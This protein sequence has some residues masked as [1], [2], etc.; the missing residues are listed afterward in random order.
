[1]NLVTSVLVVLAIC[2]PGAPTVA[3]PVA[4]SETLMA[5]ARQTSGSAGGGVLGPCSD[6]AFQTSGARW[7]TSLDWEFKAGS[8]PK[9]FRPTAVESVL[10]RAFSNVTEAR[11]DC[12]L[13]DNV[14]AQQSYLGRTT[15]AASCSTYDGHNVVAFK[16]LSGSALARTCWWTLDGR[17][18]EADI[19]I[20]NNKAWSLSLASCVNRALLEATM[21]HEVGHAFGLGH[22]SELRHGRL[23]MSPTLD[24]LCNNNEST[25]GLGDVRGLESLY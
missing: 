13:A 12:G 11:N 10:K 18:I 5:S 6:G 16:S 19:L 9:A 17:I 7:T 20:N 25:L 8:T 24:A 4:Q 1:M 23:T 15:R 3:K 22:V 14:S 21:T 2:L